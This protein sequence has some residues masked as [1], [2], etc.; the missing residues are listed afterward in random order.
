MFLCSLSRRGVQYYICCLLIPYV[1]CLKRSAKYVGFSY[2][3]SKEALRVTVFL[4]GMLC[5][6]LKSFGGGLGLQTLRACTQRW[7]PVGHGLLG[8]IL[9]NL[10]GTSVILLS[11]YDMTCSN[12]PAMAA[13]SNEKITLLVWCLAWGFFFGWENHPFDMMLGFRILLWLTLSMH[14]CFFLIIPIPSA[15]CSPPF[16][17]ATDKDYKAHLNIDKFIQF[18]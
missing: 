1:G 14:C 13:L 7:S 5:A 18:I 15:R 8:L 11:K 4:N 6:T 9:K 16:L 2:G 17:M 12:K 10:G 3:G